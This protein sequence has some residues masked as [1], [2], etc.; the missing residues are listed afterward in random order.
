[1][2]KESH[3]LSAGTCPSYFLS[4]N[5]K[6][7]YNPLLL[8]LTLIFSIQREQSKLLTYASLSL[9]DIIDLTAGHA[10]I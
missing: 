7:L 9:P 5:T 10:G 8:L 3:L 1:M 4:S 6:S 2:F